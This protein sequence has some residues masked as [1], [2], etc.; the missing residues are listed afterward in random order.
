MIPDLEIQKQKAEIYYS[1]VQKETLA[2]VEL[3]ELIEKET[4]FIEI[5]AQDCRVRAMDAEKDLAEAMPV[6]ET[7][8]K[9]VQGLEKNKK[10]IIE[11]KKYLKPPE[12]VKTVMEAVCILLHERSDWANAISVLGQMDFLQRL[13][14]Y[15][16]E[17]V[18]SSVFKKLRGI[19]TR[20][21]FSP[22]I[23]AQSSEAARSLCIWCIAMY[24][25]TEAYQT[26]KPKREKVHAMQTKLKADMEKLE[27]KQKELQ[28]VEEKVKVL[29]DECAIT[30]TQVVN[31]EK[32]ITLTIERVKRA[33]LL[34]ELLKDEG[35]KWAETLESI[36]NSLKYIETEAMI[37]A[38][39]I[40][41]LGV[42]TDE[43]RSSLKSE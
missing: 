32:N 34:L 37:N 40:N 8:I 30:E 19:V 15:N 2:A 25:F 21:E 43:Y 7:A 18:T 22:D 38:G 41:Y 26:V 20:P 36:E 4:E 29:K 14:L 3:H 9:A 33:E 17:S 24:K 13:I 35:I 10:D 16:K 5:Q 11:F 27:N 28:S 42:Y 12:A 31:L 39:T 23:V 1:E 6:L